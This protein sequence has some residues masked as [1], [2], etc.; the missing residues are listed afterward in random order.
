VW[1][2]V[3]VKRLGLIVLSPL[4]F[5]CVHSQRSAM[6]ACALDVSDFAQA[7]GAHETRDLHSA[8]HGDEV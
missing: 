4:P 6:F 3:A 2:A 8:I 5:L 1:A 7:T